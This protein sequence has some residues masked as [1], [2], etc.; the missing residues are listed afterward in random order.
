MSESSKEKQPIDMTSWVAEK[1]D[2]TLEDACKMA[3][4][5]RKTNLEVTSFEKDEIAQALFS[6]IYDSEKLSSFA[7]GNPQSWNRDWVELMF[8]QGSERFHEYMQRVNQLVP[9]ETPPAKYPTSVQNIFD[10]FDELTKY[11]QD[12][13]DKTSIRQAV[14]KLGDKL[15]HLKDEKLK[16]FGDKLLNLVDDQSVNAKMSWKH[17]ILEV[18]PMLKFALERFGTYAERQLQSW[19]K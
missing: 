4:W 17:F 18:K 7:H 12:E 16:D 9:N 11:M 6:V 1:A 8:S 15:L 10:I 14:V 2:H 19:A 13:D 5:F 3:D